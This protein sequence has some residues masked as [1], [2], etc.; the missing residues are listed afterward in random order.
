MM[1]I[2]IPGSKLFVAGQPRPVRGWRS[3]RI[4]MPSASRFDEMSLGQSDPLAGRRGFV[5]DYSGRLNSGQQ[6]GEQQQVQR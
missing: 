6:V 2:P 4:P 3:R 1:E 5:M